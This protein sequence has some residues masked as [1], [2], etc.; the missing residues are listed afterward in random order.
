[1][2]DLAEAHFPATFSAAP[3]E[4]SDTGR[5]VPHK[6]ASFIGSQ[7]VDNRRATEQQEMSGWLHVSVRKRQTLAVFVFPLVNK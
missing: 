2:Q 7:L 3:A 5:V 4:H 1:M 6:A